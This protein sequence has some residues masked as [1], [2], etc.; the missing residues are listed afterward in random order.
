MNETQT[1]DDNIRDQILALLHRA[2]RTP[3]GKYFKPTFMVIWPE[4]RKYTNCSRED[5]LREIEYLLQHGWIKEHKDRIDHSI[6]GTSKLPP[7]YMIYYKLTAKGIDFFE[8][9]GKYASDVTWKSKLPELKIEGSTIYGNITIGSNNNITYNAV[10]DIEHIIQLINQHNIETTNKTEIITLVKKELPNVLDNP[11]LNEAKSL[12]DK[13]KTFGQ[14]WLVPI[15]TQLI[16]NYLSYKL[17]LSPQAPLIPSSS[18]I[19]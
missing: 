11:N 8:N 6:I 1:A 10:S 12:I 16:A 9:P 5:A 4:I 18:H 3:K 2:Y 14:T 13:I 7:S 19:A 17:G 15:I